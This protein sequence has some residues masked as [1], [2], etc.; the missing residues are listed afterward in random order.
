MKDHANHPVR[1]LE[2]LDLWNRFADLNA[3]P[4]PSK[5][6]EARGEMAPHWASEKGLQSLQDEVGNVLIKKDATPGME[7]RKTVV[8]Q[9]HVDMVCQ[10]NEATDFDFMT[11]GIT[12][13]D[14]DWVQPGRHHVGCGQRYWGGQHFGRVEK[15]RHPPPRA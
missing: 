1:Q 6:E 2:P 12:V 7:S 8:L 5:H 11:E 13:V 4:R 3:I 9:S 15:L 10:K 14:G